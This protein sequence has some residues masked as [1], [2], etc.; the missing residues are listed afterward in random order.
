MKTRLQ[1][2]YYMSPLTTPSYSH[3][4]QMHSLN[5]HPHST[6]L[7]IYICWGRADWSIIIIIKFSQHLARQIVDSDLRVYRR[8][9]A[10]W[11]SADRTKATCSPSFPLRRH[12]STSPNLS[13]FQCSHPTSPTHHNSPLFHTSQKLPSIIFT[14]E[15]FRVESAGGSI[16]DENNPSLDPPLLPRGKSQPPDWAKIS[17][18]LDIGHCQGWTT[19]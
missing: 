3:Y 9:G 13:S 2:E 8:N 12:S 5:T 4:M 17:S 10:P 11:W 1:T 15:Y 18:G 14:L 19:F 16:R 6:L 7:K